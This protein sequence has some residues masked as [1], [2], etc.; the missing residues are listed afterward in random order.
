MI[1]NGNGI[2]YG[3]KNS[4][5]YWLENGAG[6]VTKFSDD[7]TK[8]F[9]GNYLNGKR[10]GKGK[11]Y[12][13]NGK[14]EFEGEYLN[15]KEWNGKGYDSKN[16]LIYELKNGKCFRKL[17]SSDGNL[18]FE[19]EYLNGEK[20]GKFKEYCDNKLEIEREYVNGKCME[21]IFI[22]ILKM[23]N[24]FVN[25]NILTVKNLKEKNIMMMVN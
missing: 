2:A 21:N 18:T 14:I 22:I 19:G 17:Y 16:N 25:M 20:N 1:R 11:E 10:N 5:V 13:H 6:Y 12:H 15:D 4:I 3:S 9:E 8:T 24:Y 23:E 7:G